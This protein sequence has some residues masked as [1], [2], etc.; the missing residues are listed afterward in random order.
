M[1]VALIQPTM[2]FGYR[3]TCRNRKKR[4]AQVELIVDNFAGGGGAS[5]GIEMALGRAVDIAVNHC[6]SALAM[7]EFNHP[8]TKHYCES[9]WKIDP[10]MACGGNP[11]GLAWFSPDCR[12]F[13]RAKGSKPVSRKIRCL[14]W[15]VIRW[16]R[17]VKPRL[18]MLENVREFQDW[19]PL[20][21]DVEGN[22]YPDP[23]RKGES[24]KRWIAE[25]KRC[26]YAVEYRILNA[27]DYGA[28]T[29][30]RRLFVIARS[31]GKAIKWPKPTHGPGKRK[32]WRTAAECIDWTL[33]C[34]SIFDRKKPLADK[35]LRRIA[36]GIKRYVLDNPK[37]FIVPLTHAG[38]RRNHSID[39]PMPTV[40]AAHRGELALVTPHIT[41][42]YGGNREGDEFRGND[43]GEPLRTQS[44]ENRHGVVAATL[45]PL[46]VGTAN[47]KSTGRGK[48]VDPANEPTKT[49]TTWNDKAVVAA[50]LV[51]NFGQSV[52][53]SVDDPVGTVTAGGGGKTSLVSA[54]LTKHYGGVVGH[55]LD[56]PA[57]TVTSVDHH[58]LTTAHLIKFRGDSQGVPVDDPMPTITS[59]SGAERPAGCP[60]ALGL[61]AVTLNKF[62]G[63]NV[64]QDVE[65]PLHTV[66]GQG[67]KFGLVYAFLCKYFGTA[68][69]CP[70]DEPLHT[71]T[72]KDR[73]GV[74]TVQVDG[75]T[76]AIADIGMRMLQ[77]RELAKA[78]GFPDDYVLNGSKSNQVAK[79]GNSVVPQVAKALVRANW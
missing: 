39:E 17:K 26:G 71:V 3:K 61:A 62:Y 75:V 12:H 24:F 72:S 19:G 55:E 50:S 27:A 9:V 68:I 16:A 49:L 35:T 11:V 37:P 1:T 29:H 25:L 42:Y 28:P 18:I 33:P 6:P 48:N 8:A 20:L 69:G 66:T 78:Q 36:L 74:V 56:K 10:V 2:N 59:G 65:G 70:V 52:G 21:K 40:T 57:G 44:T 51:R 7:H 45:A 34:P 13:S 14:A 76:Y 63:T 67:L 46:I 60:H 32:P 5:L 23:A 41:T 77:P 64:G 53:G 54:L 38:E 73:M 31:D 4:H 30:R 43:A 79:I 22:E 58:A 15:I 47:T